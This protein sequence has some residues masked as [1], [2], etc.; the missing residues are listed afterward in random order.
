[1]TR[2]LRRY[3]F[4]LYCFTFLLIS[5]L[6]LR[7]EAAIRGRQITRI[8]AALST[9]QIGE[10][11]RAETL[12]RIPGLKPSTTEVD[13]GPEC[14]GDEC[15][16]MF[17]GNGFPER[18]LSRTENRSLSWLLRCWGFR[19]ESVYVWA[20][21]RSGKLS[22]YSYDL[23]V[24][25][26]GMP[27]KEIPPP[28]ADGELGAVMIFVS[29]QGGINLNVPDSAEQE[30]PSYILRPGRDTPSQ[31]IG[32]ALTPSAPADLLHNA[33]D[34][35]LQCLWSLGGCRRW[36]QLLPGLPNHSQLGRGAPPST[37]PLG[38]GWAAGNLLSAQRRLWLTRLSRGSGDIRKPSA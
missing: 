18:A 20:A 21:F 36:N 22:Y 37:L 3:R 32:I 1:M 33:F 19:S 24:S 14:N 17:V 35:H 5:G 10:T 12:S 4:F 16:F 38:P 6:A 26:P 29:S 31:S 8:V 25:A 28:P 2:H 11:S 15:F 13:G 30:H 34:L 27:V 9:L 23:K 7:L